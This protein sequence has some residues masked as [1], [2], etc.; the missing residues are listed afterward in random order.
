MQKYEKKFDT[1]RKNTNFAKLF[2]N[3]HPNGT[4]DERLSQWSAKPSRAVRLR[5]VPRNCQAICLAIFFVA[6]YFR[7]IICNSIFFSLILCFD[8]IHYY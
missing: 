3:K 7:H 6:H 8:T 1:L 2:A 5:Q 4:L